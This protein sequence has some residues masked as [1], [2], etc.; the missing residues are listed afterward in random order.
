[1]AAQNYP[2]SVRDRAPG[3]L[4]EM[5]RRKAASAGGGLYEY[6]TWTTALSQTC[7]CG[8]QVKKELSLR[9]HRC[10]CGVVAQRDLFSA[11]LGL[12]VRPEPD[13]EDPEKM[14]DLLDVGQAYA[15]WPAAHDMEW[16]PASE[17]AVA[18]SKRRGQVRPSRRSVARIKQRRLPP[19]PTSDGVVRHEP[20]YLGPTAV[21]A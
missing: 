15:S 12:F 2:R 9:T 21:A 19:P 10:G 13:V 8:A 18:Q 4:I 6:S 3:L 11:F 14:I 16:L 5:A 7:V 1:V 17:T 20:V